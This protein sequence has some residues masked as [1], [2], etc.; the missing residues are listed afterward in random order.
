M[1]E[2]TKPNKRHF[3]QIHLS[4]AVVLM[5][6]SGCL[7]WGNFKILFWSSDIQMFFGWP[8]DFHK[9][10]PMVGEVIRFGDVVRIELSPKAVLADAAVAV[11]ILFAVW[12]IG[13]WLIRR[14][15]GPQDMSDPETERSAKS[16]GASPDSDRIDFRDCGVCIP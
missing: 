1:S 5:F 9:F 3:W 4:T 2:Q 8:F 12:G 6:V 11:A 7:L 10:T 15:E 14:H 13:E 16:G